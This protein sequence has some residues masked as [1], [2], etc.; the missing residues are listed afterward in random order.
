MSIHDVDLVRERCSGLEYVG[1]RVR[2]D[3]G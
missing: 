3:R 2:L 1:D